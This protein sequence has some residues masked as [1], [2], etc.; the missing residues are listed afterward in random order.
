MYGVR[1]DHQIIC[2]GPHQ[3]LLIDFIG[4][5]ATSGDVVHVCATR[6]G[7]DG[8][9]TV[10][11]VHNTSVQD[12]TVTGRYPAVEQMIQ[13]ALAALDGTG[14]STLVPTELQEIP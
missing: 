11:A 9:W 3:M 2:A 13:H 1:T 10:H 8:D 6:P 14:Y 4:P 5:G 7:I 12:V